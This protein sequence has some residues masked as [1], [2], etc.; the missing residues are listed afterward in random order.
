MALIDLTG[1]E[2]TGKSNTKNK[3]I[4]CHTSRN[5]DD[6]LI[7]LKY[8]LPKNFKKIPNYIISREGEVFKLLDDNDYSLFFRSDE[9]NQDSIIISLE[10]LGW[11][12]KKPLSN[13][14]INWIGN[15]YK[16]PVF[17]K[18]WRDY[19]FWEPYTKQQQAMVAEICKEICNNNS[20]KYENIG[21]NVKIKLN[22][23]LSG[24]FCRANLDTL[25]TDLNPSFDFNI[26]NN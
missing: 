7:S 6:Y 26:F 2:A 24:I 20:I 9:L 22:K 25:A 12:E 8:R 16:K 18:K 11:L 4:L 10:N 5:L 21:H 3:I 13:D 23:D 17:E 19:H 1:F 15:I 14:Y